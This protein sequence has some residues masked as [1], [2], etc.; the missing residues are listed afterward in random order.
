MTTETSGV[1]NFDTMKQ[2][3]PNPA[4]SSSIVDVAIDDFDLKMAEVD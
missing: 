4:V 2:K 3:F 1:A